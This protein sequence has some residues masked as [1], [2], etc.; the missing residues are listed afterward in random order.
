MSANPNLDPRQLGPELL[1]NE[2][3]HLPS[4]G[5][6]HEHDAP[7]DPSLTSYIGSGRSV[8]PVDRGPIITGGDSGVGPAIA[9]GYAR[10]GADVRVKAE[11]EHV[12]RLEIVVNNAASQRVREP[13]AEVGPELLERTSQTKLYPRLCSCKARR[14]RNTPEEGLFATPR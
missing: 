14:K 5:K 8:E 1:F 4:P 12:S 13:V 9:I 10:E 7:A 11:T 3:N 6:V 2:Q